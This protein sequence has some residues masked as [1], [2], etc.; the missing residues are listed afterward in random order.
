MRKQ[1]DRRSASHAGGNAALF[2]LRQWL[3][4]R[5]AFLPKMRCFLCNASA[6]A[7]AISVAPGRSGHAGTGRA[8]IARG[9]GHCIVPTVRGPAQSR[10]PLLR[11]MRSD[12]R[13]AI[14]QRRSG[15]GA[16][17]RCAGA[18]AGSRQGA[19]SDA[20]ACRIHGASAAY[21]NRDRDRDC[22]CGNAGCATASA[23]QRQ[24]RA[25]QTAA[26]GGDRRDPHRADS[27]RRRRF[28]WL[29]HAGQPRRCDSGWGDAGHSGRR[30]GRGH[31]RHSHHRCPA[32]RCGANPATCCGANRAIGRHRQPGAAHRLPSGAQPRRTRRDAA[33]ATSGAAC[34]ACQ[35]STDAIGG[36]AGS[37]AKAGTGA[38]T[39]TC[40]ATGWQRHER[41]DL[42]GA[43]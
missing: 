43:R 35:Q 17:R 8:C 40:A 2:W 24:G 42:R 27:H 13:S 25:G 6:S 31:R 5:C 38:R 33:C 41:C 28:L 1:L 20:P 3:Q 39:Q 32:I 11:E 10:R 14:D 34:C 9:I 19:S 22:D 26:D 7:I 37:A 4:G 15:I 12:D 23:C 29:A 36:K 21:C 18:R 16:Q 30:T